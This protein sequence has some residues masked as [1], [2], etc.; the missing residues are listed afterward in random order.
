MSR[1]KSTLGKYAKLNQFHRKEKNQNPFQIL[2]PWLSVIANW[3]IRTDVIL[4]DNIY[5]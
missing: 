3:T 4:P 1:K 2:S 5:M